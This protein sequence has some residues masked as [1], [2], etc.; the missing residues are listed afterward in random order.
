MGGHEGLGPILPPRKRLGCPRTQIWRSAIYLWHYCHQR[1]GYGFCRPPRGGGCRILGRNRTCLVAA[2]SNLPHRTTRRHSLRGL[3]L[4]GGLFSRPR[5]AS[6]FHLPG[7]WKRGRSWAVHCWSLAGAND[8][9]LYHCPELR[10]HPLGTKRPTP[11]QLGTRC[12]SLANHLG[13]YPSQRPLWNF[14]W[15]LAGPW[16][17]DR[18]NH[19]SCHGHR[20]R[21]PHRFHFRPRLLNPQRSRQPNAGR[22]QHAPQRLGRL[23]LGPFRYQLGHQYP[24]PLDSPGR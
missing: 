7:G 15:L 13:R 21:S 14:G 8:C 4:L 18:R 3:W 2:G 11:S 5:T 19:G 9:P 20:K 17:C 22:K 10:C 12:K 1:F 6:P 24:C 16:S 23:G